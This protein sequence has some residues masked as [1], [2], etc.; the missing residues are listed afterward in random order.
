VNGVLSAL[1]VIGLLSAIGLTAQEPGSRPGRG[2]EV[3]APGGKVTVDGCVQSAPAGSTS[4]AK[5]ILAGVR[6]SPRG[7]GAGR[8]AG[9]PDAGGTST[10]GAT[11]ATGTGA[12]APA[13]AGA[14]PRGR[15]TGAGGPG[16]GGPGA[17]APV[18]YQLD[19]D[20]KIITPHV[21]H[22]VEITGTLSGEPAP[23]TR[24]GGPGAAAAPITQTLKIDTLKMVA[25]LCQ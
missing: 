23:S 6:P 2:A 14:G 4:T 18:R 20:E 8:A 11:P 15:G 12:V 21:N 17:A 5:F 25:A 3:G 24:T 19:G 13:T 9:D 1:A 16:A 10:E 22:V 7:A